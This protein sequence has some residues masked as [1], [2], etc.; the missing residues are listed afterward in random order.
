MVRYLSESDVSRLLSM[1]RA[2]EQVERALK[3][4]AEGRA[5]DLPRQRTRQP[6]TT[7]HILQG[8]APELNLIGYKAYTT[9]ASGKRFLVHLFEATTG[10]PVAIVSAAYL[11]MM[12]TGAANAVAARW[13]ARP[14]ASVIGMFGAGW[15]AQG[16]LEALL[17]VRPIRQAR[18][19]ARHSEKLMAFCRQMAERLGIEVV[20]VADQHEAVAGCDIITTITNAAHPLFDSAWIKPGQHLNAA[21]SNAL[22]RQELSEAAIRR[23]NRIVVDSREVAA[24]ECGDLLPLYEKGLIDYR[25][26]PELGEIIAGRAAGR[27]SG[28]QVTLFESHGMAIQD[29]YVAA[30]LLQLARDQAIGTDLPIDA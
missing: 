18:V 1:P 11:G 23:C 12:R 16:Q 4:L 30:D 14:D 25:H 10:K 19:F 13:L 2:I 29:L 28:D 26:L 24:N 8:A 15:Q 3:D 7:L 20:P 6:A 21:G 27:T 9:N 5:T 17:L 22:N